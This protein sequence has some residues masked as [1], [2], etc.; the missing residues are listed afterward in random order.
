VLRLK[1]YGCSYFSRFILRFNGV[2]FL[3]VGDVPVDSKAFVVTSSISRFAGP[4]Q[5]FG[6]AYRDR[7]CVHAFIGG[8]C[9]LVFVSVSVCN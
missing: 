5:L 7:V 2:I 6:G 4:T 9:T 8:E 1:I 3:V